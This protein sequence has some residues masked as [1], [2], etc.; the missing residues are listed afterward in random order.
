MFCQTAAIVTVMALVGAKAEESGEARLSLGGPRQVTAVIR[1][2]G[3]NLEIAIRMI[4]VG[5]FDPATNNRLNREKAKA[6]AIQAL[7][8]H[9]GAKRSITIKG[10]T[11]GEAR[12]EGRAYSLV[13]SV[14]KNGVVVTEA[15]QS[16]PDRKEMQAEKIDPKT[17]HGL[18]TAKDDYTATLRLLSA[19][20]LEEL[21]PRPKEASR[22]DDFFKA[23]ADLEESGTKSLSLLRKEV[24]ADKRLLRMEVDE[25]VALIDKE[26]ATF[27]DRLKREVDRF[28]ATKKE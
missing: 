28:Q 23:I 25:I 6:Y 26:E 9:L 20:M 11:F 4:R 17:F 27:T 15:V 7:A 2:R 19:S 10:L 18:L 8:R 1:E 13:V 16:D 3:E 22:E 24:E 12:N 14:P 5:C 21:P